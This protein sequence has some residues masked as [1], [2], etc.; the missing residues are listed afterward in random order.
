MLPPGG[1]SVLPPGGSVLPP[2]GASSQGV[3]FQLGGC[4][5][6]GGVPGGDMPLGRLGAGGRY[7][8][9]WDAFLFVICF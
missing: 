3:Y 1:G 8:S 7:A 6:L 4:F 2:K 9:Y 5:L